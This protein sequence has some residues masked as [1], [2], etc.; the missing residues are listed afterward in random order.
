MKFQS[1]FSIKNQKYE[2]NQGEK[3]SLESYPNLKK[4]GKKVKLQKRNSSKVQKTNKIQKLT[5][6][7]SNLTVQL[8][9]A[10]K[11]KVQ[12]GDKLAGRHGNKGI[13]SQILPR[14]DM[15]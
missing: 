3:S 8:Y 4:Q 7:A 6:S 14:Q 9:L 13:I 5:L 15:P 2:F 11:R 12:V 10:E 1:L